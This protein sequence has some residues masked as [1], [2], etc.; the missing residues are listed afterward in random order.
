MSK[1]YRNLLVRLLAAG[2]SIAAVAA[3]M[4]TD[5]FEFLENKSTDYQFCLRDYLRPAK[6][7]DAI[8]I[9]A[10]DDATMDFIDKP[11]IFWY[12]EFSRE[13]RAITRGGA[14]VIGFDVI[15]L[16]QAKNEFCGADPSVRLESQKAAGIVVSPVVIRQSPGPDG[17]VSVNFK[18][19]R[20]YD[21]YLEQMIGKG[22]LRTAS[23]DAN[24]KFLEII[25]KAG[26]TKDYGFVN[27][28]YDDDGTVRRVRLTEDPA[29]LFGTKDAPATPT[30]ASFALAVFFS[31]QGRDWRTITATTTKISGA[32]PIIP[33]ENGTMRIDYAGPP[34]TFTRVSMKAV[35]QHEKDDA[36][37]KNYFAGRIVIIGADTISLQ[38]IHPTPYNLVRLG[39]SR[40]MTGPEVQANIVHTLLDRQFIRTAGPRLDL[41]ILAAFSLASVFLLNRLSLGAGL[42]TLALLMVVWL[43]AAFALF[44]NYR[45]VLPV[46][47]GAAA[48]PLSFLAGYVGSN[49][50]IERDHRF[51]QRV[52]N[53]Y[54]DPRIVR[55]VAKSGDL[56]ILTGQRKDVTVLFT[57]IRGYTTM[58]ETMSAEDVVRVLN[59]HLGMLSEVILESGGMVVSYI[60]DAIMAMWNAPYE[61]PDHRL[62]ACQCAL[63]MQRTVTQINEQ[64]HQAGLMPGREIRIGVGLN[65]GPAVVG[66]LGSERR[67]DYTAIGDTVNVAA[68]LEGMNKNFET[69]III[70]EAVCAELKGQLVLRDLGQHQ[71]RGRNEPLQIYELLGLV[72]NNLADGA[73]NLSGRQT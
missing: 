60:G 17:A 10:I 32:G 71:V 33:L 30:L 25:R 28:N 51:L 47:A 46:M 20:L 50:I 44:V 3:V 4:R 65:S 61:L 19:S 58:S 39:N 27:L 45:F 13:I 8:V 67:A 6:A 29:S 66:N 16:A 69:G 9:A 22:Y 62:R 42:V 24:L 7:P 40:N 68:R 35:L 18:F 1:L 14:R 37:L 64:L 21:L 43:A 26:L 15:E 31:A 38:D 59:L 34:G 12:D 2:L 57:D 52:F 63:E 41:L 11:F 49:L 56:S 53:R 5:L 48:L 23:P 54:L 55:E 70:S 36:F 73:R 72:E